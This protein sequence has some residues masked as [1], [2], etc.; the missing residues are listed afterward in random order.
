MCDSQFAKKPA[1]PHLAVAPIEKPFATDT[2]RDPVVDQVV[3][4]R[5]TAVDEVFSCTDHASFIALH[6]RLSRAFNP[7]CRFRP[8]TQG[9]ALG[10]V[11]VAPLALSTGRSN[12]RTICA[13]HL[14]DFN[15]LC[16]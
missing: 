12:S 5:A 9:V 8:G 13:C 4:A 2:A 3:G 6:Q 7:P 10:R 1:Q 16:V 11:D 15:R 14:L